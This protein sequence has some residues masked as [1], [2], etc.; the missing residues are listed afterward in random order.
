MLLLH[1]SHM[2]VSYVYKRVNLKALCVHLDKIT[3][4][5]SLRTKDGKKIP[6]YTKTKVMLLRDK[7]RET[8]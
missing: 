5:F 6:V 3:K 8:F 4:Q 7:E 1:D 2:I